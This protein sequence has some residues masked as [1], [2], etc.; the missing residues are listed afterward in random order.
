MACR[1]W[2]SEG[3]PTGKN[4]SAPGAELT[5]AEMANLAADGA[6]QVRW[7]QWLAAGAAS[8]GTRTTKIGATTIVATV[9]PGGSQRN[10]MLFSVGANGSHGMPPNNVDKRKAVMLLVNDAKWSGWSD[11]EIARQCE[12]GHPFV[13]KHH[14]E[15]SLESDSSEEFPQRANTTKHGTKAKMMT[16][17]QKKAAAQ[18]KA[19]GTAGTAAKATQA[20]VPSAQ[21]TDDSER[22]GKVVRA[23]RSSLFAATSEESPLCHVSHRAV[24]SYRASLTHLDSEKSPQCHV[25]NK[26]VG[27]VRRSLSSDDSEESPSAPTP[28]STAPNSRWTWPARWMPPR[29]RRPERLQPRQRPQPRRRLRPHQS[30]HKNQTRWRACLSW[31]PPGRSGDRWCAPGALHGPGGAPGAQGLVAWQLRLCP[32]ALRAG[33]WCDQ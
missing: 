14:M 11:R 10:A 12:V 13:A 32:A 30:Q 22:I 33:R 1:E 24:A 3:R 19:A 20:A 18:M 23:V 27:D 29:S 28:P 6:H 15:L 17:G 31:W 26:L 9:R 4:N 21:A 8:A 16:G 2:A 7:S 25:G 5:A